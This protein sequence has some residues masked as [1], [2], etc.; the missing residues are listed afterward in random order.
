MQQDWNKLCVV[1]ATG[2]IDSR[3]IWIFVANDRSRWSLPLADESIV[4]LQVHHYVLK[5]ISM[6]C[7]D[8]ELAFHSF[9]SVHAV[10][11]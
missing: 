4:A 11:E 6:E 8:F 9:T 2:E 5:H 3:L 10:R 1:P 7:D